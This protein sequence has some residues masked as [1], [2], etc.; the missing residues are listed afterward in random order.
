MTPLPFEVA[1]S[2]SIVLAVQ[3][4]EKADEAG[5]KVDKWGRQ[6][7]EEAY[8]AGDRAEDAL[9]NTDAKVWASALPVYSPR[10]PIFERIWRI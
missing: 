10:Q 7:K 9:Y 1:T 4:A 6:T 5:E 2:L 3:V 8:R